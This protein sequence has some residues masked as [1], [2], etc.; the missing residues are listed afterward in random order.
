MASRIA[1]VS[2]KGNRLNL[3][4]AAVKGTYD[5]EMSADGKTLTGNWR[6]AGLDLPLTMTRG[7]GFDEGNR[8]PSL[9]PWRRYWAYGKDHLMR[10]LQSFAFDSR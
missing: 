1:D 9:R 7:S 4:V 10:D 5:A 3:D 6:Q 2:L 8:Q